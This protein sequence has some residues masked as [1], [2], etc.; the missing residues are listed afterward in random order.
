MK[1]NFNAAMNSLHTAGDAAQGDKLGKKG[2]LKGGVS[3]LWI[4][5]SD[6]ISQ[7]RVHIF[8]SFSNLNLR[9]P[10]YPI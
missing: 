5:S 9:K 1:E 2:G 10:I 8:I 3:I 4:L 7:L 6:A